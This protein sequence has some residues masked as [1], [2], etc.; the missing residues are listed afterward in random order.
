MPAGPGPVFAFTRTLTQLKMSK[1]TNSSRS[2]S[3]AI[4][5]TRSA[6]SRGYGKNPGSL[7]DTSH[8]FM[9]KPRVHES[10]YASSRSS[11]G[12]VVLN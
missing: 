7:L 1:E 9:D 6:Q 5:T 4:S 8:L 2:K 3:I 12:K 11:Q 10:S